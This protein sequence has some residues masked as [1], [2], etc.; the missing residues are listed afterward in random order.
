MS[1]DLRHDLIAIGWV[2]TFYNHLA[3]MQWQ[4]TNC[5]QNKHV[6]KKS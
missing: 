5:N 6:Q 1:M 2:L 4:P 3:N